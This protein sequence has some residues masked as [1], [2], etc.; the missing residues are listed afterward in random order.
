MVRF[1]IYNLK[2]EIVQSTKLM[3]KI[4]IRLTELADNCLSS[5]VANYV[6]HI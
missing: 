5:F 1:Q 6:N 2:L 4:L 3:A